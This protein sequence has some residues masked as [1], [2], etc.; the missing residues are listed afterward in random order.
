[1]P[2]CVTWSYET[3]PPFLPYPHVYPWR[4]KSYVQVHARPPRIPQGVSHCSSGML[5]A[6]H[7][8]LT[9]LSQRCSTRFHQHELSVRVV[10]FWN[11]LM[12]EKDQAA[13][14]ESFKIWVGAN[15]RFSFQEIYIPPLLTISSLCAFNKTSTLQPSPDCYM[16]PHLVFYGGQSKFHEVYIFV[17]TGLT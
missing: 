17:H 13:S 8:A 3:A 7:L 11:K 10:P 9:F 16:P 12:T 4:S 1:M 14:V 5:R 15:W 6:N 2:V